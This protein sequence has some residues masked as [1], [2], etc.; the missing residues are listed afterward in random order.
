MLEFGDIVTLENNI[1]YVV[2]STC[3]YESV[4]YVYLVNI[5]DNSDC[6]LGCVQDDS[7][8]QVTDSRL[9]EQVIVQILDNVDV[10]LLND[11]EENG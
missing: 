6:I 9:F 11:G 2:A 3:Y 8:V 4:F 10:S 7:L 1:K 5:N